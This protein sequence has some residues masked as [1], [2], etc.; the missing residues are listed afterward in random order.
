MRKAWHIVSAQEIL[1]TLTIM[2]LHANH[3]YCTF[4]VNKIK[5]NVS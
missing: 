2:T 5:E 3:Y 1:A 4:N